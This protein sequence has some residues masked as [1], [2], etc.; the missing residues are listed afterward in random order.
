MLY[1][2][3][4]KQALSGWLKCND[5]CSYASSLKLQKFLLF[6]ESFSKINNDEYDF[7]RLCG[8][9]RGPVF[10]AVWGD[11]TKESLLFESAIVEQYQSNGAFINQERAL[12]AGFLVKIM[13]ESELSELTHR[14]DLWKSKEKQIYSRQKNVPLSEKNFSENDINIFI[15]LE[16]LYSKDFIEN[17]SVIR[18]NNK[19]F[20]LNKEEAAQLTEKNFDVLESLSKM[21]ELMNPVMVTLNEGRLEID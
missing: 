6:Y 11:Y 1:S 13:S 18:I 3:T 5:E 20:V 8:Y 7:T 21:D 17:S 4:R 9:E 16:N 15:E 12:K 10:S 14:L 19:Y 2:N